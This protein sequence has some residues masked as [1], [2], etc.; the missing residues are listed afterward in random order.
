[1]K[2]SPATPPTYWLSRDGGRAEGPLSLEELWEGWKKREIVGWDMV[3][4]VGQQH[5]RKPDS[6]L[7]WRILRPKLILWG[8]ITLVMIGLLSWGAVALSAR[9]KAISEYESRPEV[10]EMRQKEAA[11]RR[12]NQAHT[13]Y[14]ITPSAWDGSVR[15]A[16]LFIEK[17]VRDPSSLKYNDWDTRVNGDNLSTSVDFTATNGFGGPARETWM[18][19]FN[20]ATGTLKWVL[21]ASDGK[22]I[23]GKAE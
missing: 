22:M 6:V 2:T 3:C 5:W 12:A 19:S 15:E 9:I 11:Q 20:R 17:A 4:P 13:S 21:N 14:A 10:I 8:S 16:K 1:M 18:F 23:Y 7:R